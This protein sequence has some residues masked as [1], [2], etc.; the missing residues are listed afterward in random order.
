[1]L[2]ESIGPDECQ[3][4]PGYWSD[5]LGAPRDLAIS[6]AHPT[7]DRRFRLLGGQPPATARFT[8]RLNLWQFMAAVVLGVV[9]VAAL[10]A[11]VTNHDTP[12]MAAVARSAEKISGNVLSVSS[13]AENNPLPLFEKLKPEC[14]GGDALS[15][16]A[17][18]SFVDDPSALVPEPSVASQRCCTQCHHAGSEIR[19][20]QTA[21]AHLDHYCIACHDSSG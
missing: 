16:I 2:R 1:M 6:L 19:L 14:R 12:R 3:E 9:L 17:A 8:Q 21:K 13:E 15:P 7:G 18:V 20:S 4:L 10:Q 5:S 11:V